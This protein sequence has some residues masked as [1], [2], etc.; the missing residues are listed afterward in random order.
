VKVQIF[1]RYW[2]SAMVVVQQRWLTGDGGGP[3]ADPVWVD[4]GG[5]G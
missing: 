3:G 4:G 5:L 2:S 1:R